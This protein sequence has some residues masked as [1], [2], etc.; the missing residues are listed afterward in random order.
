MGDDPDFEVRVRCAKILALLARW[1]HFA[2]IAAGDRAFVVELQADALL[3]D[4]CRD[5]SR[6]VRRVC[7]DGLLEMKR[8]Y[9]I[10]GGSEVAEAD[11]ERSGKRQTVERGEESFY[12]KLCD[13]DFARLESTLTAEHLYQEALDTQVEKMMTETQDPNIGNNILD[14]Y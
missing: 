11:E 8:S 1:M 3:L 2:G 4:M 6:Y 14:C 10:G 12:R 13:I 5:S 7:L 9:E